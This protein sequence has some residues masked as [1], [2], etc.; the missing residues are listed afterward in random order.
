MS[1]KVTADDPESGLVFDSVAWH[2]DFMVQVA[3][4]KEINRFDGGCE[5]TIYTID[6]RKV[7]VEYREVIE[8]LVALVDAVEV[9]QR[10]PAPTI[11]GR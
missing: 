2:G 8:A 9:H 5:G 3:F 1:Y 6:R 7:P 4:V 11:P 10:A